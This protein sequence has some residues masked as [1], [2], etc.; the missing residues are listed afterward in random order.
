MANLLRS[1]LF[2]PSN[3]TET[4]YKMHN[5]TAVGRKDTALFVS[6]ASDTT[7]VEVRSI[8]A[9]LIKF[10]IPPPPLVIL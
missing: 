8:S 2:P 6:K 4:L 10:M 1:L 9:V 7:R 5:Y 3:L